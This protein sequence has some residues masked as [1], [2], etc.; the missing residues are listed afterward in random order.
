M[1]YPLILKQPLPKAVAQGRVFFCWSRQAAVDTLWF[2]VFFLSAQGD[3]N[4]QCPGKT[5]GKDAVEFAWWKHLTIDVGNCVRNHAT[6]WCTFPATSCWLQP[7]TMTI[8]FSPLFLKACVGRPARHGMF[9]LSRQTLHGYGLWWWRVWPCNLRIGEFRW[10][11][12]SPE[13]EQQKAVKGSYS[14]HPFF[15]VRFSVSFRGKDNCSSLTFFP[16][17]IKQERLNHKHPAPF[18][19]EHKKATQ[20]GM[21]HPFQKSPFVENIYVYLTESLYTKNTKIDSFK[22]SFKPCHLDKHVIFF[23][24][25][26]GQVPATSFAIPNMFN[27]TILFPMTPNQSIKIVICWWGT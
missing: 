5:P 10:R 20:S 11:I 16:W 14:N 7:I 2:Y 4:G 24:T 13:V 17:I 19:V 6:R 23:G 3:N 27:W 12:V 25:F 1:G 15:Q 18:L 8:D 21:K 9:V 22:P 26:P